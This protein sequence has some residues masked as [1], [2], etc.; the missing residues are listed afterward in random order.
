MPMRRVIVESPYAGRSENEIAE[1][2]DYA[3]ACVRDCILRG[4]APFASHLLYTQPGVLNDAIPDERSN[5][6]RAGFAWVESADATVV[7]TNLGISRGMKAGIQQAEKHGKPVEYR[8]ILGDQFAVSEDD[9]TSPG[10]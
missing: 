10:E 3:R 4:E 7:Y 8:T 9:A 2:I 5:S 6:M 1:N